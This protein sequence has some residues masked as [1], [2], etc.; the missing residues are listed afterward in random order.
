MTLDGKLFYFRSSATAI[1][2]LEVFPI[3]VFITL[4]AEAVSTSETSVSMYEITRRNIQKDSRLQFPI[5]HD[6][7]FETRR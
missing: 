1:Q 2:L 3:Q 7:F 5:G 4:M 6:R